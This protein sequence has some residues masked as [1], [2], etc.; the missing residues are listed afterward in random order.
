MVENDVKQEILK[1]Y[2]EEHKRPVDIAPIINK[3]PQYVSKVL[4]GH[5]KYEEEKQIRSK[6]K[7]NNYLERKKKN[8]QLRAEILKAK[9]NYEL[10][11][12]RYLQFQHSIEMSKKYLV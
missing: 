9:E 12:L 11:Y 1:L 10:E 5:P 3:S 4:K 2:Y 7:H 8:R 6:I